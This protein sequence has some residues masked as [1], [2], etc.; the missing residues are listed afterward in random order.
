MLR[1]LV[2]SLIEHEQIVTTYAKAKETARL[3][4]KVISWGKRS[5]RVQKQLANAFLLVS[6]GFSRNY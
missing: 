5:G 6:L 2:A 3:A 1:N 4:E